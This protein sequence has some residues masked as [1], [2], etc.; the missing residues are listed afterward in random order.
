MTKK[1]N[2][3]KDIVHFQIVDSL[4]PK[5]RMGIDVVDQIEKELTKHGS[6]V[7]IGKEYYID[8]ISELDEKEPELW[9]IDSNGKRVRFID[10]INTN[11]DITVRKNKQ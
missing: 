11:V 3:E 1:K 5:W 4:A 9:I 10:Q 8:E 6:K 2:S 7:V